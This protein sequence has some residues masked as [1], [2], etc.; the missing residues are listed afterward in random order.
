MLNRIVAEDESGV[1]HCQPES[2]RASM[3]WK[4]SSLPSNKQFK[5]TSTPSFGKVMLTVFWDSQGVLLAN[6]Q[7]RGENVT[8]ASYCE[9]LLKLQNVISRK[10]LEG[11]SLLQ[12]DNARPHTARATQER[13]Q[14]LQ[15]ELP[16]LLPYSPG[17][18]SRAAVP[19]PSLRTCSAPGSHSTAT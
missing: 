18:A 6:F 7:K 1:H 16:E 14:E 19:V 5:F 8:S 15:W 11:C 9:V 3:Q 13:I 10:R 12:H 2:K 17:L 4:Y